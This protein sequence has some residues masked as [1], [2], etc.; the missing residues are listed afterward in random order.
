MR[1]LIYFSLL[2]SFLGCD[3]DNSSHHNTQPHPTKSIST[4][5]QAIKIDTNTPIKDIETGKNYTGESTCTFIINGQALDPEDHFIKDGK[6]LVY[7]YLLP[8]LYDLKLVININERELVSNTVTVNITSASF[9]QQVSFNLVETAPGMVGFIANYC[10]L[11]MKDNQYIF[12]QDED[13]SFEVVTNNEDCSSNGIK[14]RLFNADDEE[15][16]VSN[17]EFDENLTATFGFDLADIEINQV[18][19]FKVSLYLINSDLASSE[20]MIAVLPRADEMNQ[21]PPANIDE[22]EGNIEAIAEQE[23]NENITVNYNSVINRDTGSIL[24]TFSLPFPSIQ[25]TNST[26][27]YVLS[28]SSNGVICDNTF[29]F[30]D[31]N[32]MALNSYNYS[33]ESTTDVAL[34]VTIA[35]GFDSYQFTFDFSN[36]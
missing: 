32:A 20:F 13:L 33:I 5:R 27:N 4:H 24:T 35:N 25:I 8:N 26:G 21:M 3:S 23:G 6:L 22:I 15:I 34:D 16:A 36:F 17:V 9:L 28:S 31:L 10:E 12:F 19:E 1:H 2:L 11:E 30:L 7:K 14:A 18:T 29:C